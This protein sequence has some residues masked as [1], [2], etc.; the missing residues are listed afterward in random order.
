MLSDARLFLNYINDHYDTLKSKYKTMCAQNQ[1]DWDEDVFS[2]TILSCYNAIEKKGKLD[3]TTP[4]GIQNYFFRS[5]K[6]NTKREKQYCRVT[7][8][9]LNYNSDN[10]TPIYEDWYNDT[11]DTEV[12]KVRMDLYRDF[13]TLYIMMQVEDNWDGEHFRLFNLKTLDHNM[14]YKKLAEKTKCTNVRQK[15]IDVR[16]WVREN[17]TKKE[18]N[19][20]FN[21]IYGDLM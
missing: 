7:K 21:L 15:V 6:Q 16:N 3:D 5:F 11:K 18:I 8:R 2:N 13:A 10:I 12:N 4:Q 17:V 9:D 20:A 14:T 1:L 19:D